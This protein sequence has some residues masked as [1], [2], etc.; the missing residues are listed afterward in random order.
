MDF[1]KTYITLYSFL[2]FFAI[3]LF[4]GDIKRSKNKASKVVLKKDRFNPWISLTEKSSEDNDLDVLFSRSGLPIN[5][6]QYKIIRML[7]IL[8]CISIFIYLSI[9]KGFSSIGILLIVIAILI[10][11]PRNSFLGKPTPFAYII[12]TFIKARQNKIDRELFRIVI[13]LKNLSYLGQDNYGYS[14]DYIIEQLTEFAETT[15]PI[16]LRMLSIWQLGDRE[17]ASNYLAKK[18]NTKTGKDLASLFLKLD[19]LDI[20]ELKEQINAYQAT[21]KAENHTRAERRNQSRA[22]IL[23]GF[24]VLTASLI[25]LNFIVIV[26]YI[27]VIKDLMLSF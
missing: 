10:T 5:S 4:A 8:A 15:K 2:S 12:S 23:Y 22:N 26:L 9:S 27:D 16:F 20:K 11:S 6:S 13:Q 21:V 24:A 3:W 25:I 14:S 19:F 18:L 1:Y 17:G 7:F